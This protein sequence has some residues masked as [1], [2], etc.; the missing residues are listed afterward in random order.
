MAEGQVFRKTKQVE[1]TVLVEEEYK[2]YVLRLTEDEAK[3]LVVILRRVGGSPDFIRGDAERVLDALKSTIGNYTA[4][5][6]EQ[7]KGHLV[8][9]DIE[10]KDLKPYSSYVRIN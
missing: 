5:E 4:N 8:F 1:K 6:K 9:G 3:T 2:E 7:L 10:A